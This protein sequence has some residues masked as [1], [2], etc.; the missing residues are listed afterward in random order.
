V[1]GSG[2]A[3]FNAEQAGYSDLYERHGYR[4]FGMIACDPPGTSRVF[5]AEPLK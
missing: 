1:I 5:M 2:L 3:K 4:A